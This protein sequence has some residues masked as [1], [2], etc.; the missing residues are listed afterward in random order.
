VIIIRGFY[1]FLV[2]SSASLLCSPTCNRELNHQSTSFRFSRQYYPLL[3]YPLS[4]SQAYLERILS[5]RYSAQCNGFIL[6]DIFSE[7]YIKY[8]LIPL[9]R[10]SYT[11]KA[12]V[13]YGLIRIDTA[14]E[15]NWYSAL[16]A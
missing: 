12:R 4:L 14:I 8:V 9:S 5:S 2:V 10:A 3:Y 11:N 6:L 15:S 13:L 1:R 7:E 16:Y